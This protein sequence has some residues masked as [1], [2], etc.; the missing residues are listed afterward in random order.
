[1]WKRLSGG[2]GEKGCKIGLLS[3][4]AKTLIRSS[5]GP[6]AFQRGEKPLCG[7]IRGGAHQIGVI[8]K[9]CMRLISSRVLK[10]KSLGAG[11]TSLMGVN[12]GRGSTSHAMAERTRG[13]YEGKRVSR[14]ALFY[15]ITMGKT[16]ERAKENPKEGE[17]GD[18]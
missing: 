17:L 18:G 1:V 4:S 10:A 7:I 13:S 11:I 14:G 6:P 8:S 2:S 16:G 5:E 3:L 15:W 12:V 9:E